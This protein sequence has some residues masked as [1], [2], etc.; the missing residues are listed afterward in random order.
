MGFLV[1]A[2]EGMKAAI[3][4]LRVYD[5]WS[6]SGDRSLPTCFL[7]L[8]LATTAAAF[9]LSSSLRRNDLKKVEE[10]DHRHR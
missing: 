6:E 1:F 4:L 9:F 7:P 2:P 8:F 5:G 10:V 3:G